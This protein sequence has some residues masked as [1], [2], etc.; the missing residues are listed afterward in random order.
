[1]EQTATTLSAA[2]STFSKLQIRIAVSVFFFCQGICFASWASRIPDMKT[3]LQLSEAALGSILLALPAGQLTMMPF[4]GKLVTRFGSKYVLRL[5]AIGYA[6]TLI[7]IGSTTSSWQL[8]LALY[9]FGLTG[10]LCNISVNTQAVNAE[11]LFGRSILASFH[12]VWSTAGFT[13]ALVG[14]LM[15]RLELIPVYHFM[16]IAA[17]VITLNFSFQKY[18]IITPVSRTASSFKRFQFPKGLLLQLG[19][20][21]FCCL[22]AEG[23]MFDWSGVYFKEVV[24]VKGS[25]VSLGY[26]S[27]MVMMATGRFTG[28]K[29][30]E[31]FGRKK[32]VQLSGVLIFSGMMI[33]VLLP[34]IIFATIGFMIVGF[35]VSSIIPLVYSTAGKVKEVA[36]GIAIATVSGVGFLGFLMGPP[37]IGYIAELAGLRSSFAV[38]AVL[39]L[40]ISY[41]ISKIKLA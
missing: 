15:M 19:L 6:L 14:L 32:M 30:A 41:M 11:H 13:G 4:S 20:I 38:I 23:C 33:A 16:I 31:R 34:N 18:L 36:S 9:L 28:D 17:I 27:F 25:L 2:N 12:G 29:L 5:A 7:L 35:G 37:L 40:V 8:A 24:E 26:A 21:A 22:S 10:N 39:G 3:T 1:M